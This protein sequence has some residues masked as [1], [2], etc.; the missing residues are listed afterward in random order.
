MSSRASYKEKLKKIHIKEREDIKAAREVRKERLRHVQEVYAIPPKEKAT[1]GELAIMIGFVLETGENGTK[2][3]RQYAKQVNKSDKWIK[4]VAKP[5]AGEGF[6]L[7]LDSYVDNPIVLSMIENKVYDR[8][9]ILNNSVTGALAKL[10]KQRNI[11]K[12]IDDLKKEVSD[13]KNMLAMKTSLEQE[14]KSDWK[15]RAQE[16]RDSGKTIREIANILGVSHGAV[17]NNTCASKK[18]P[19]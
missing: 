12:V 3:I 16:L 19:K 10:A 18:A 5:R 14:D 2:A 6:K 4:E 8:K 9:D 11:S 1:I 15:K 7:A 13:L 17:G